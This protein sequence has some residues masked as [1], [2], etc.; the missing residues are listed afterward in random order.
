MQTQHH[1]SLPYTE[2]KLSQLIDDILTGD[3]VTLETPNGDKFELVYK[4]FST[5]RLSNVTET[6]TFTDVNYMGQN[7]DGQK[8][9]SN[10]PTQKYSTFWRHLRETEDGHAVFDK[11]E[12]IKV[13]ISNKYEVS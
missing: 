7:Y 11:D 1:V 12:F 5:P 9:N 8:Y 3:T 4:L 13:V 6:F 10:D 2:T